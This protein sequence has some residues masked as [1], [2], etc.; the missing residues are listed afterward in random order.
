MRKPLAIL[1]IV[2]CLT[3]TLHA[4]EPGPILQSAARHAARMT[5]VRGQ[6]TDCQV[7]ARQGEQDGRARQGSGGWF[8]GGLLLTPFFVPIM[9]IVAHTGDPTPPA[10]ALSG[11]SRDDMGCYTT[12]YVRAAKGKR[13]KAA[14]IGYGVSAGLWAALVSTL[15]ASDGY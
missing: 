14:W 2:G 6:Q 5:L 15:V 13:V 7:A 12:G 11:I 8:A 4:A 10:D 9:P 1:T 3:G